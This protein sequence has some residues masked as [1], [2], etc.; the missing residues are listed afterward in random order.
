MKSKLLLS[1]LLGFA[2]PAQEQEGTTVQTTLSQ[3]RHE[4]EAY[5][6]VQV[7]LTVQFV[8]LGRIANPFFTKFT[9][10]EYANF[11][12]WGDEQPIW[13]QKA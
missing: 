10:T 11:Y 6:N 4:P 3:I 12:V 13:R 1:F 8:S 5:K 7:E 2:L 9:P